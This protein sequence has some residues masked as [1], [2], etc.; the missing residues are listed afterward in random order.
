[1]AIKYSNPG[2]GA[3]GFPGASHPA[4]LATKML[5]DLVRQHH[6][7]RPDIG[8]GGR[9][10]YAKVPKIPLPR[11]PASSGNPVPSLQ[12]KSLKLPRPGLPYLQLAEFML[13][14]VNPTPD[15]P[16][17]PAAAQIKQMYGWSSLGVCREDP[18]INWYG[19]GLEP[20]TQPTWC[21]TNQAWG[22]ASGN[23]GL[24]PAGTTGRI[25]FMGHPHD[26]FGSERWDTI[27]SFYRPAPTLFDTPWPGSVTET[28]LLDGFPD[29][30]GFRE[31]GNGD[32][33]PEAQPLAPPVVETTIETKPDGPT[34]TTTAEPAWPKEPNH[35]HRKFMLAA[36][37]LVKKALVITEVGDVVDCIWNALPSNVRRQRH[38][39]NGN[40]GKVNSDKERAFRREEARKK[41]TLRDYK[42]AVNL[43][44]TGAGGKSPHQDHVNSIP[45]TDKIADILL[46]F[47]T[48]DQPHPG[49]RAPK[50]G[51]PGTG[52]G[53]GRTRGEI[54][55]ECIALN[56]GK[57]RGIG[58]LGQHLKDANAVLSKYGR[59]NLGLGPAL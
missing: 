42:P 59:T 35:P 4:D 5:E 47:P 41:R 22:L 50:D 31:T 29:P 32:P 51:K 17:T 21:L 12:P 58:A 36:P 19:D 45:I 55:V 44:I 7:A 30:T 52:Q 26:F 13:A 37:G 56:E 25:T 54:A 3:R 46:H 38:I 34:I 11:P 6:N 43:K 39:K 40:Y 1:M 15:Y 16:T 20:A 53:L 27:E 14:Q 33:K 9:F 10:P 2:A 48:L 18:P 8:T 24:I 28:V 57:D 23:T 49:D